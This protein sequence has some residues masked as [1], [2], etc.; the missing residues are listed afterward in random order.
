[1]V[2]LLGCTRTLQLEKK[3][4]TWQLKKKIMNYSTEFKQSLAMEPIKP[5]N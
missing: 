5:Y 2:A 4:E 1:M 3:L